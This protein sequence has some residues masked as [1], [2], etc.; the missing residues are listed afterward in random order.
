MIDGAFSIV[1]LLGSYDETTKNALND[2]KE[3][4]AKTFEGKVFAFLLDN[5]EIYITDQ[6]QVLAEIENAQQITLYF[7]E[8]S[9][10]TDV[11]TLN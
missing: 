2:I 7:F 5:L 11:K 1:L 3:E 9:S 6:F 8:N 10:L 4:I